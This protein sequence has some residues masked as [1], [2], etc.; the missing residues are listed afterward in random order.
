MPNVNNLSPIDKLAE[1]YTSKPS[2]QA[3]AL[4]LPQTTQLSGLLKLRADEIAKIRAKVFFEELDNGKMELT[5]KM[6]QSEDFVHRFVITAKAA[7]N[8]FRHEKIRRFAQLFRSSIQNNTIDNT[9]EYEEHLQIIDDLSEREYLLLCILE[10]YEKSLPLESIPYVEC[11][12]KD[13]Q[14]YKEVKRAK[15]IWSE[16]T[17]ESSS[18]LNISSQT[19]ANMLTRI[20]RT[21]C[22]E[23]LVSHLYFDKVHVE[24]KLTSTWFRIRSL[25]DEKD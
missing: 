3:L 24:G 8:T 20:A 16:F 15:S 14:E 18:C 7:V 19:T 2:L 12:Q 10:K 25:V 6:I 5:P 4:F 17:S 9:D 11:D 1:Y 23:T 21:G 13:I 22:Y